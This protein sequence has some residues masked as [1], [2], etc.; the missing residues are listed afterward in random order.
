MKEIIFPQHEE[1]F[2]KNRLLN[3]VL[4]LFIEHFDTI[5]DA[6]MQIN[7]CKRNYF[8][9]EDYNIAQSAII[10]LS[11][12]EIKELYKKCG[13]QTDYWGICYTEQ[14]FYRTI[15]DIADYISE[16][17]NTLSSWKKLITN[18]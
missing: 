10:F 8:H 2:R 13:Y 7:Y 3:E 18:L 16:H 6:L 15:R 1:A 12:H 4:K 9:L 11:S 17:Q 5:E 14:K